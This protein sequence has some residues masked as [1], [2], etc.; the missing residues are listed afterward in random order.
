MVTFLPDFTRQEQAVRSPVEEKV[1]SKTMFCSPF[2]VPLSQEE[3]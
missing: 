3:V 2:G 1:P